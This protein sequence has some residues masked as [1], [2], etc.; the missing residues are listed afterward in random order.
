MTTPERETS[1]D[2]QKFIERL[3]AAILKGFGSDAPWWADRVAEDA[4]SNVMALLGDIETSTGH[5][6][7]VKGWGW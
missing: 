3:E 5:P 4:A 2:E 6:V 1:A 7:K